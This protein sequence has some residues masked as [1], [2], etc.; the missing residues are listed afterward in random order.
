MLR[1]MVRS[2]T[3]LTLDESHANLFQSSTVMG[4]VGFA[5][6]CLCHCGE[7][8]EFCSC[9][10]WKET[11]SDSDCGS[12]RKYCQQ[13]YPTPRRPAPTPCRSCDAGC[14]GSAVKRRVAHR[15]R[16]RPRHRHP[17]HVQVGAGRGGCARVRAG[18]GRAS[19]NSDLLHPRSRSSSTLPQSCASAKGHF[20]TLSAILIRSE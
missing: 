4:P 5:G 3:Q 16:H 1:L 2:R 19:H 18:A 20:E 13:P 15:A 14:G 6:R 12:E 11:N 17:L 8:F 7:S 10:R 9:H